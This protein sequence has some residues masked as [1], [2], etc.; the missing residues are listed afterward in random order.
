MMLLLSATAAIQKAYLEPSSEDSNAGF[1]V[2]L[3]ELLQQYN[4][5]DQGDTV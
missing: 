2:Q 1:T 3:G 5:V 4:D